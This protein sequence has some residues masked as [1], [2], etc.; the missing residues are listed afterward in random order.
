[1]WYNGRL[2]SMAHRE[3]HNSPSSGTPVAEASGITD[4]ARQSAP[5]LFAAWMANHQHIDREFGHVYLYHPRSDAHSVRL[6]ELILA[7]LQEACP[8]LRQHG[9]AGL[10]AYGIN[11]RYRWPRT[12]KVKTL[13]L[14]IGMPASRSSMPPVGLA[15]A[16]EFA[17][18]LLSCEA[19]TVMTEHKKSQPRVFDELASSHEIVHQGQ[20]DAIAAGITVVNIASR[21]VSPLRNRS[22]HTPL[23]V[24]AHR[25]PDV[26]A[27]IV[28]HL[29]G[30]PIRDKVG[31]VG[32]DAYCTIVVDCDN[33]TYCRLHTEPPSPQP[34]DRDHYGTFLRRL[35]ACY[36]ERFASLR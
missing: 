3:V 2:T 4:P 35:A 6:C 15:K 16:T 13:D 25:Q 23:K 26:T 36:V 30:L 21:F 14:A 9:A 17:Q 29:R 10:V 24:T 1:M 8:L 32:F 11:V 12:G 33:Q 22:F 18:V 5:A 28:G 20:P 19:K 27:S 7:D 34:G 31:A